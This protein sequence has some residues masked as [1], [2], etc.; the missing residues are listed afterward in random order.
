[1]FLKCGL[2]T[3]IADIVDNVTV[4]QRFNK[5]EEIVNFMKRKKLAY[6][7]R[8]IDVLLPKNPRQWYGV[9]TT[10]LF[11]TAVEIIQLISNILGKHGTLRKIPIAYLDVHTL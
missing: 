7:I 2:S 5:E 11:G 6:V 3:K 4:M 8:K 9:S 10:T 1:M